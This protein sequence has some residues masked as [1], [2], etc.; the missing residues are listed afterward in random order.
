MALE[1]AADFRIYIEDVSDLFILKPTEAKAR[2]IKEL[3]LELRSYEGKKNLVL[4]TT[5]KAWG[6]EKPSNEKLEEIFK[7]LGFKRVV[8]QVATGRSPDFGIMRG[9]LDSILDAN[10]E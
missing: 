1:D 2:S 7:D 9:D 10:M 6:K 8:V 4:L 5:S 3:E